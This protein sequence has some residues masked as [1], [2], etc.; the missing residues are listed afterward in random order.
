MATRWGPGIVATSRGVPRAPNRGIRNHT[1][2]RRRLHRRR[3]NGQKAPPGP[4]TADPMHGVIDT[5]RCR[6]AHASMGA[7]R[8]SFRAPR[9]FPFAQLLRAACAVVCRGLASPTAPPRGKPHGCRVGF[10]RHRQRTDFTRLAGHADRWRTRRCTALSG[11]RNAMVL[12][13]AT[14][15]GFAD[16]GDRVLGSVGPPCPL[17]RGL[18]HRTC[19]FDH[20]ASQGSPEV[21]SARGRL[22]ERQGHSKPDVCRASD[23]ARAFLLWIAAIFE[24]DEVVHAFADRDVQNGVGAQ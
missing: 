8:T 24:V 21:C 13:L 3:R 11:Q 5:A 14:L 20:M 23:I 15:A 6:R 1:R 7:I 4:R 9:V 22:S 10:L 16:V 17:R 18:R 2:N 12:S 19:R